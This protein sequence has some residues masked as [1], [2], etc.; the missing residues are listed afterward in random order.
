MPEKEALKLKAI[1]I[2]GRDTEP[3]AVWRLS[4]RF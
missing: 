4:G 2:I 1:R 3:L